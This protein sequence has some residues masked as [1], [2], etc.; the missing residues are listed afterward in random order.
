MR[1][2]QHWP[3]P[4]PLARCHPTAQS[5]Y[6]K[7]ARRSAMTTMKRWRVEIFVGEDEGRTYAEAR[8][9]TEVGDHLVGVGRARLNPDEDDVP[10]IGDEIG[11]LA[12]ESEEA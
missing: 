1:A 5:R 3:G 10:E 8:L 11:A 6:R 9:R 2:E 7:D 4:S 12:I